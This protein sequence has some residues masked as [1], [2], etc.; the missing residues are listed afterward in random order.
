MHR[1][2]TAS[3]SST[4]SFP[5]QNLAPT[6]FQGLKVLSLKVH[7]RFPDQNSYWLPAFSGLL[8]VL[9]AA[10]NLRTLDIHEYLPSADV[11]RDMVTT[12]STFVARTISLHHPP[13]HAIEYTPL[14]VAESPRS[15]P[16]RNICLFPRF[17]HTFVL[18]AGHSVLRGRAPHQAAHQRP[19]RLVHSARGTAGRVALVLE[20]LR[21]DVGITSVLL[22]QFITQLPLGPIQTIKCLTLHGSSFEEVAPVLGLSTDHGTAEPPDIHCLGIFQFA[23]TSGTWTGFLEALRERKASGSPLRKLTLHRCSGISTDRMQALREAVDEFIVD[24]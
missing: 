23:F 15:Q 7:L 1:V 19:E 4:Y 22:Q 11:H 13:R 3:I 16:R 21:Q 14:V 2:S 8:D 9:E 20:F 18:S 24:A 10:V 12:D 6:F 17:T 5:G